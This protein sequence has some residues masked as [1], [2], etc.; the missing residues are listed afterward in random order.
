MCGIAGI[1][2]HDGGP[3]DLSLV[4]TMTE[5]L[6]HRG[7]DD[8]G[9]WSDHRVGLGH[10]RLSIIDLGGSTQPMTD[11]RWHLVFNG[12]IFNFRELRRSLKHRFRTDGD[13]EVV[14]AIFAEHGL[15]GLTALRGQFAFAA[16]DSVEGTT[17]LVRDR[18]G[19]LPLHYA[20][21]AAGIA[22][23]SEV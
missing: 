23:A 18:L 7:P 10:R 4:A 13:T 15:R 9:V 14:L 5:R 6:R 20:D 17:W 1:V 21:N 12:E 2:R 11:G 19:V 3:V 8:A 22:F 16:Y